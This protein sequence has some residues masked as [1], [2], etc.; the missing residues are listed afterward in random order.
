ML[1]SGRGGSGILPKSGRPSGGDFFSTSSKP[2]SSGV[3]NFS[4]VVSSRRI[5]V[6]P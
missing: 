1:P 3:L 2:E 4:I 6:A 5:N